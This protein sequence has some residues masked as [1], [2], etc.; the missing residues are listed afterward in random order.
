MITASHN[1]GPGTDSNLPQQRHAHLRRTGIMD[2]KRIVQEEDFAPTAPAKGA[3][4]LR[5]RP[6]PYANTS[7]NSPTSATR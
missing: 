7:A 2:I 1:P 4:T 6:P 5:H 3:I